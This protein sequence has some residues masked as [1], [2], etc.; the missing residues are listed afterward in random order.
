MPGGVLELLDGDDDGDSGPQPSGP[1]VLLGDEDGDEVGEGGAELLGACVGLGCLV[2]VAWC[3]G[4]GVKVG[5]GGGVY[6]SCP[7][8]GAVPSRLAGG[9]KLSTGTPSMSLAIT[10]VHVRAG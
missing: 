5:D 4:D 2:G 7:V 3:V 8:S 6:G 9:G 10:D 1:Q